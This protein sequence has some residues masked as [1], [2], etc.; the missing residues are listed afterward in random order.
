MTGSNSS[1][2]SALTP[3]APAS[4]QLSSTEAPDRF[5]RR[6]VGWEIRN[7]RCLVNPAGNRLCVVDHIP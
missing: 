7:Q 6:A 5:G 3:L 1:P 2:P 4:D